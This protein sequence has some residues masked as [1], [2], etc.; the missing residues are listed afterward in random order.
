MKQ[1][2]EKI[3][4]SLKEAVQSI[5]S[6]PKQAVYSLGLIT[7]ILGSDM[8][9]KYF[10]VKNLVI[11]E[12]VDFLGGFLRITLVYN[13]GGVFGILQGYKNMFLIIS[14]I[15]LILMMAYY[16]IEKNKTL[17]FTFSMSLIIAG[18][19]G[20][21]L[22]RL[23]PDRPG[24]VD[25]ISVGVDSVYRWP[26]FNVADSSIVVGAFLL[27]IVFFREEKRRKLEEKAS[28]NDTTHNL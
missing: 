5:K 11:G 6:D 16:F 13:Q 22:D 23:I 25:F 21:I 10:I 17:L 8:V 26:A 24:V 1:I 20:N 27:A 28:G 15:V 18:A 12:R 4:N 19:L 14:I 3:R 9:T 7:G 2:L